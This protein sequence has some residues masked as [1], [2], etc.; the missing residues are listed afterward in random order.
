MPTL[1]EP[2]ISASVYYLADGRRVSLQLC[3]KLYCGEIR[4]WRLTPYR[5]YPIHHHTRRIHLIVEKP[6]GFKWIPVLVLQ[7]HPILVHVVLYTPYTLRASFPLKTVRRKERKALSDKLSHLSH[8]PP[9][10]PAPY[11]REIPG[12][13]LQLGRACLQQY[14]STYNLRVHLHLLHTSDTRR[15]H[16]CTDRTILKTTPLPAIT[17]KHINDSADSLHLNN[18]PI[19]Y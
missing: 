17:A 4:Y 12:P 11:D 16:E 18:T 6:R 15:M 3:N 10:S 14:S 7:L 5:S 8:I 13:P 2:I 9:I 1:V 19:L